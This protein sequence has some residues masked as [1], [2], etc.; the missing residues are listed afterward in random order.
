MSVADL[1]IDNLKE[2]IGTVEHFLSMAETVAKFTPTKT[3][4]ALVAKAEMFVGLVKPL[5]D[6]PW[7]AEALDLFKHLLARDVDP[8]KVILLLK[9]L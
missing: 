1:T 4:D 9:S 2:A 7:A 8:L 3:D 5:L 6:K